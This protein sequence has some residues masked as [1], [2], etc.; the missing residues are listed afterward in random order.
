MM[1]LS[2]L[3][4]FALAVP[5][6]GMSANPIRRVVTMLQKMQK[7]VE[8]EGE[9][10]KEL[11]EKFECYCK[12][13]GGDL[14]AS[15][16]KAAEQVPVLEAGVKEAA[17]KKASL[18]AELIEHR[19]DREEA[20]ASVA[21]AKKMREKEAAAFAEESGDTGK[22]IKALGKAVDAISKG[23]SFLQTD[24]QAIEQIK[25]IVGSSRLVEDDREEVMS[26]L[27]TGQ[28]RGGT[29]EIVGIL[30]QL[31]EDMEKDLGD[32]V[33]QE[34]KAKS[35]YESLVSAKNKEIAGAT[36]AIEKKTQR[37]GETAVQLVNL[38]NDLEDTKDALG[39][40]QKFA[41][42]L[43]KNCSTK[44]E[45]NDE[46][47][48]TRSQELAAIAETIKILN[49]D[50][51]LDLFK[52]TLPSKQSF[53]QLG[54]SEKRLRAKAISMFQTFSR[55]G[56]TQLDLISLALRGKKVGFDKVL[57]MIDDMVVLLKKEQ[58]DDD[59]KKGYC[60][61]SLDSAEDSAKDTKRV[62]SDLATEI[63][64]IK[65]NIS[66]LGAAIEELQTGVAALD[67]SVAEATE[68]RKAEHVEYQDLMSSNTAAKQLIE[69]AKN[70]LNKFYNPRVYK[71][72][73]KRELTEEE[74]LFVAGG[75]ELEPTPAPG[76]IAGTGITVFLQSRKDAPAAA[77]ETFEGG[78]KK[79]SG[80]SGGVIAMLDMLIKDL[81]TEIQEAEH[82]EKEAQKDYDELLT[83]A[84]DKRSA[85][86]QS[87]LEKEDQKATAEETLV[88]R[89]EAKTGKEAELAA[90]NEYLHSLHQDCD[91]LTQNYEERKEKRS[92]EIDGLT[93]SKAVLSGADFQ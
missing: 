91:F 17:A 12:T 40:D 61:Q 72:P 70:R 93:K 92:N 5:S 1:K 8:N 86:S 34:N 82:N 69:F 15:I 81:D 43:R 53:L 84:K 56:G 48:V 46:R 16:S 45:E 67:K 30:K 76:G 64:G 42:E 49:D 10:E 6:F 66:T 37:L 33:E 21:K 77:P 78:Y 57:K 87:I 19:K 50:D 47:Q 71:A 2:L 4:L 25:S 58:V 9:K 80:D 7:K 13:S 60:E 18:G 28:A 79:K 55:G 62:V 35:E 59:D 54:N 24:A 31:K 73:P 32:I 11:F 38:K 27:S 90:L 88:N 41:L 3:I 44:S 65:E 51:A 74:R 22:N 63:T 75:G 39:E 14:E 52:K 36:A 23:L 68:Q 26:F 85:D 20:N 29:G 83:D 89:S